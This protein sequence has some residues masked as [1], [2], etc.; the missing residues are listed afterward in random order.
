[1]FNVFLEDGYDLSIIIYDLSSLIWKNHKKTV[2]LRAKIVT[3]FDINN[4]ATEYF[5]NL[6]AI[7]ALLAVCPCA[8]ASY[9]G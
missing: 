2:N 8:E 1:M 9:K 6:G 4:E 3:F 5:S 7:H